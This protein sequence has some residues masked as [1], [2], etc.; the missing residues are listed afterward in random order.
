[1]YNA[2]IIVRQKKGLLDPQGTAIS[3]ALSSLGFSQVTEVKVGKFIEIR[4]R[5]KNKA[6]AGKKAEEMCKK[7]LANPVIETYSYEIEEE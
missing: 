2:K 4:M 6:E 3:G 7:L 5:A 1:M